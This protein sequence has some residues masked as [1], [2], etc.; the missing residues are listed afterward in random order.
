MDFL[1]QCVILL[2]PQSNLLGGF[3]PG[4]RGKRTLSEYSIR[5]I[6]ARVK[7]VSNGREIG[8]RALPMALDE[9]HQG[10]VYFLAG[11][12]YIVK[13]LLYPD[14]MYMRVNFD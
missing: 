10:A 9:L 4:A 2:H 5:G 11:T 7:I 8:E 3:C 6:G 13:Q 12:K 14:K 1:D